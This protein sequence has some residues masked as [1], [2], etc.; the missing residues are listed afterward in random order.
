MLIINN[1]DTAKLLSMGDAID[2]LDQAYRDLVTTE[3]G[4]AHFEVRFRRRIL[5]DWFFVELSAR[6]G[7]PRE[8]LIEERETNLGIGIE[9]EMQFGDWPGRPQER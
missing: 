2:A 5:R 7:W 3:A 8:F 6:V 4:Q 1:E 9:F